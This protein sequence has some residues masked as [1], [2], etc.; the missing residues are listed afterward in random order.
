[1]PQEEQPKKKVAPDGKVMKQ[2]ALQLDETTS[3]LVKLLFDHDM[4]KEAMSNLQIDVEK[5]PL[6]KI[7]KAQIAKGCVFLC[8]REFFFQRSLS[9]SLS[10]SPNPFLSTD[11]RCWR[12]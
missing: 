3:K 9:R 8:A 4:F 11:T 10:R 1:L 7:S 6:G 2:K 5:M 12:R